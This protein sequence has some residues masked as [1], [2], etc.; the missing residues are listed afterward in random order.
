M[1]I[2]DHGCD[3]QAKRRICRP[4]PC[5]C[6][7]AANRVSASRR[8]PWLELLAISAAHTLDALR[9]K[10]TR[11]DAPQLLQADQ[12]ADALKVDMKEWS[13]PTAVNFFGRI[14]RTSILE[15]LSEATGK[16]P[17]RFW[18]KLKKPVLATHTERASD[19]TEWLPT[20]RLPQTDEAESKAMDEAA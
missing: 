7:A 2:T 14:S 5:P 16:P 1:A 19:G 12:L 17:A 20:S 4:C 13:T 6:C 18:S 11:P 3:R 9:T 10:A 8:E 15:A